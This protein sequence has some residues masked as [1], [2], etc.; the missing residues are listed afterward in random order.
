[1]TYVDVL[2]QY[3]HQALPY[4]RAIVVPLSPLWE[5]GAPVLLAEGT[6]DCIVVSPW[7]LQD[8]LASARIRGYV[9]AHNHVTTLPPRPSPADLRAVVE[10][11]EALRPWAEYQMRD[12]AILNQHGEI[13]SFVASRIFEN[14]VVHGRR[15]VEEGKRLAAA[16]R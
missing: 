13:F 1:M 8:V 5:P 16:G 11:R 3:Y 2:K 7:R 10:L 6:D 4:E 14:P 15:F 9:L 12:M